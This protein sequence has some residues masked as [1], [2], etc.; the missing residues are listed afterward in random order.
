MAL[1]GIYLAILSWTVLWELEVPWVDHPSARVLKLV[2]YVSTE[3]AGP[4][5]ATEI[6]LNIA[7]FIPFGIYLRH[8]MPSWSGVRI[9]SLIATTSVLFEATQ[10]LLAIG[11]TD[12]ADVINNSLGGLLGIALLAATRRTLRGRTESIL[13]RV[14]LLG[15]MC[16]LTVVTVYV[17]ASPLHIG[18]P[19]APMPPL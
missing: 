15:T 7:L 5:S 9:L 19:P 17:L 10:Y 1:F 11:V 12:T 14:M 3:S 18:G 4:N 13:L 8:L 6:A 16:V 2:P